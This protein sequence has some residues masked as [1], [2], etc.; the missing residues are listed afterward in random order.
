MKISLILLFFIAIF[1][2]NGT[3]VSFPLQDRAN[4]TLLFLIENNITKVGDLDLV[5]LRRRNNQVMYQPIENSTTIVLTGRDSAFFGNN[6]IYSE[7]EYADTENASALNLL[8]LHELLGSQ[9][10]NDNEYQLSIYLMLLY[11][12]I[13]HDQNIYGTTQNVLPNFFFEENLILNDVLSTSGGS[14]G[15]G[16]GGDLDA[17]L[18]KFELLSRFPLLSTNLERTLSLINLQFEPNSDDPAAKLIRITEKKFSNVPFGKFIT[19]DSNSLITKYTILP[20]ILVPNHYSKMT[21]QEQYIALLQ[22]A[23]FL[24]KYF[25][26]FFNI[27]NFKINQRE[28]VNLAHCEGK[29]FNI[30]KDVLNHEVVINSNVID[31]Y[32]ADFNLLCGIN[33]DNLLP[34]PITD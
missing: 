2:C 21:R 23:D 18:F 14:T 7:I 34:D 31:N 29:E 26:M 9:G 8:A 10:Y 28:F 5:D 17:A 22:T 33:A 27:N 4:N 19:Y 30:R 1:P 25:D 6:T 3:T 11:S 24:N 13:A 12:K 16:G 32:I 15:I 20:R